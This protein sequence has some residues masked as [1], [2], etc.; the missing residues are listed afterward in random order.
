MKLAELQKAGREGGPA[1]LPGSPPGLKR[2]LQDVW[3]LP[4]PPLGGPHSHAFVLHRHV[5]FRHVEQDELNLEPDRLL[6]PTV[7]L[8]AQP[9]PEELAA[10]H[11]EAF[12][13]EYWR[14]LFHAKLHGTLEKMD[15]E[16]RLTLADIR[17]R[18]EHIGQT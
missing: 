10:G 12:L 15:Q 4:P 17:D 13:L 3:Q 7:I 16:G 5:L 1:G 8:L 11:R 18:I 2:L 6:P 9:A 14:R